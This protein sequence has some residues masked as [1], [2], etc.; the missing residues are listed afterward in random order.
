MTG[1]GMTESR[2]LEYTV[3]YML[4]VARIGA[5]MDFFVPTREFILWADETFGDRPWVDLG[6][7]RGLLVSLLRHQGMRA[8]G[9]DVFPSVVAMIPDIVPQ[10]AEKFIYAEPG[11]Y[12]ICRPCRGGWIRETIDKAVAGAG[13]CVYVGIDKHH[14]LD[15][16]PLPYHTEKVMTNAG[17]D[18]E[19]VWIIRKKS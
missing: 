5:T 15:I 6:C 12:S 3:S 18:G 14:E 17:T 10:M 19:S 1:Q 11:I 7:G 16:A 13:I 9:V 2:M 4:D 8:I